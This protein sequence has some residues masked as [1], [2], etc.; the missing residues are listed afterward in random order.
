MSWFSSSNAEDSLKTQLK[1]TTEVFEEKI[2]DLQTKLDLQTDELTELKIQLLAHRQVAEDYKTQFDA[3]KT[4]LSY[5]PFLTQSYMNNTY[6]YYDGTIYQ[7]DMLNET[8]PVPH[9]YGTMLH[10]NGTRYVGHWKHG[11]Y[12]GKGTL[13]MSYEWVFHAEWDHH[14]IHGL[15]WYEGYPQEQYHYDQLL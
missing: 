3:F 12:H 11:L 14:R 1:Q 8:H 13:Y 7:G 9:G 4:K 10:S 6:I 5:Y 15:G 2:T